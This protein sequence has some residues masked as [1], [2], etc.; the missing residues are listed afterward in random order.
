MLKHGVILQDHSIVQGV[1]AH[2]DPFH[3]LH[4][5]RV[6]LLHHGVVCTMAGEQFLKL[7]FVH[8]VTRFPIQIDV[9]IETRVSLVG[10]SVE[11]NLT[12]YFILAEGLRGNM[13]CAEGVVIH[14]ICGISALS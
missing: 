3:V 13:D 4:V 12:D 5:L 10:S 11:G 9:F 2:V 8:V 6:H 14:F 7:K 1:L